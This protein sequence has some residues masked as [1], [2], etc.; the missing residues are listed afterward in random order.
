MAG[1]ISPAWVARLDEELPNLRAAVDWLLAR[2]EATRALR[3]LV[4]AE[5][6]WTQRHPSYAELHRWLEAALAAAPDAPARDRALA[7]WLLSYGN[8]ALGHD[9]AA[10]HHAQRLLAVAEKVDDPASLGFAHLALAIVW[11][12]RGDIARAAAAYAEYPAL[13]G[14]QTATKTALCMRRP[15]WPTNLS[16]KVTS[17]RACRCLRTR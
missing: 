7:H 4:A 12:D 17:R 5:D 8:G 16:C 14:Q 10:L 1:H 3:L 9:E 11:E 15:N 13:V 2:G 6:F